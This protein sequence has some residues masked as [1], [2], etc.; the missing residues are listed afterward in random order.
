MNIIGFARG[1]FTS[2]VNYC[3]EVYLFGPRKIKGFFGE[4]AL[5]H[6]GTGLQGI[7]ATVLLAE[8]V[9][10][11]IGRLGNRS[12]VSNRKKPPC[13]FEG[14]NSRCRFTRDFIAVAEGIIIDGGKI[15]VSFADTTGLSS[16]DIPES[17]IPGYLNVSNTPGL[18]SSKRLIRESA[19]SLPASNLIKSQEIVSNKCLRGINTGLR[20]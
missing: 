15:E 9:A 18:S 7:S 6:L 12:S 1:R 13:L 20:K 5:A 16:T 19:N 10:G 14:A 11:Q 2:G 17:L 8:G 3:F 4:R